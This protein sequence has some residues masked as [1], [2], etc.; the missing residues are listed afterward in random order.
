MVILFSIEERSLGI[1][2]WFSPLT[3]EGSWIANLFRELQAAGI[4]PSGENNNVA[5]ID[6]EEAIKKVVA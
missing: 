5:D 3:I 1:F 2:N 4:Q 6:H